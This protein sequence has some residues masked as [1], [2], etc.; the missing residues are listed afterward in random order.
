M[1][2]IDFNVL[3]KVDF[4]CILLTIYEKETSEMAYR[5]DGVRIYSDRSKSYLELEGGIIIL[6]NS[7][8]LVLG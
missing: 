6:G 7:G 5:K 1:K 8:G 2:S 4:V 3:H